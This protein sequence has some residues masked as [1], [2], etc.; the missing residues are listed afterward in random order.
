MGRKVSDTAPR[1]TIA[2]GADALVLLEDPLFEGLDSSSTAHVL[3][4][5]IKKIGDWDLVFDRPAGRRLG[6]RAG[7]A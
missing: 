6:L 2:A 4:C 3:S 1:K 5:A 7:R